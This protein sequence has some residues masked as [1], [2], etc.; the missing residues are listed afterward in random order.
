MSNK[1][2]KRVHISGW[3]EVFL[4]DTIMAR[5]AHYLTTPTLF[6]LLLGVNKELRNRATQTKRWNR[7]MNYQE[8]V[9]N[10]GQRGTR[11]SESQNILQKFIKHLLYS[12]RVCSFCFA[13]CGWQY[14]RP[15]AY[16]LK[17][18]GACGIARGMLVRW[19]EFRQMFARP[20]GVYMR[21]P[22]HMLYRHELDTY[23]PKFYKEEEL[24]EVAW[25]TTRKGRFFCHGSLWNTCP[26][27][28]T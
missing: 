24:C 22:N 7:I 19:D 23:E 20:L 6:Q 9:A 12:P 5:I 28:S 15:Q 13:C 8:R 26:R 16:G 4:A 14:D 11:Y 3:L 2:V 18:C 25:G 10:L 27:S 17:M 1:R 21:C